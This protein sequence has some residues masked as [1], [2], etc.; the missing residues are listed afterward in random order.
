MVVPDAARRGRDLRRGR[1]DRAVAGNDAV[2]VREPDSATEAT[3]V[4]E[5][6]IRITGVVEEVS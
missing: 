2:V 6:T 3:R 5:C 4:M 1:T